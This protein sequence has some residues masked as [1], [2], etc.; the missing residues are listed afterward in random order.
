MCRIGIEFVVLMFWFELGE[1][2]GG[3]AGDIYNIDHDIISW[4]TMGFMLFKI[5]CLSQMF[6]KR[7]K[8]RTT[9]PLTL[10]Q[11]AFHLLLLH[12]IQRIVDIL[13]IITHYIINLSDL[14]QQHFILVL[15]VV[16]AMGIQDLYY[17]VV[18]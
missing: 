15:Y 17:R 9:Q 2:G 16:G 6:T 11:C 1:V 8:S 18:D 14:V 12:I 5:K 10:L 13:Y 4:C 7:L 3:I